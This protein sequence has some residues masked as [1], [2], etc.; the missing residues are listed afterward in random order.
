MKNKEIEKVYL[1]KIKK[2]KKYDKAYFDKDNPVVP[3]KNYDEIKKEIL[4]LE[5]KYKHLK[6]KDSP[7][8]KIGY[9]PSG[10]YK[11]VKHEVQMLSLSKAFSLDNM[12][13]SLISSLIK[14]STIFDLFASCFLNKIF[15]FS[16]DKSCPTE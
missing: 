5:T 12:P 10:K 13:S 15:S 3:D 6:H 7:S 1:N 2:I 14:S 11:K 8:S 4:D 9:K 16:I